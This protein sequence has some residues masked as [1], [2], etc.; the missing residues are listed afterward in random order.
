MIN[1]GLA[2]RVVLVTGG[3]SGIGAA[4]SRAFADQ[5]AKVAIHYVDGVANP[6]DGAI[7]STTPRH[8]RWP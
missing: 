4:V 1:T 2:G 7:G 5:G 3:V 8:E 6:P